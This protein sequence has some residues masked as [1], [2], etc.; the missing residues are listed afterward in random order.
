MLRASFGNRM[1][2]FYSRSVR[3]F[4]VFATFTV[5][6]FLVGITL[7]SS[8]ATAA[9]STRILTKRGSP[10]LISAASMFGDSEKQTVELVGDVQMTFDGQSLRADRATMDKA[11][12]VIKAEGNVIIASPSAYV[13][14]SRA[15]LSYEDNTGLIF[16]GFVKSGQVMFQGKV[17]RKVGVDKY[18]AEQASY[19][20]CTTCPPAWSFSGRQ[21]DA[22]IGAYAHIKSATFFLGGV[23]FFW[24]PYLIVP[25]KSERQSGILFPSYELDIDGFAFGIPF[26]WA[27]SRSQ[28]MTLTPKYYTKRGL[29][30]LINYRYVLNAESEGELN[31]GGFLKDSVFSQDTGLPTRPG[32]ERS[33][34]WFLNHNHIYSL[35]GGF[36]NRAR[37]ALVSDL[38]YTRDFPEDMGGLGEPALENRLSLTKNSERGHSSIEVGYYVNQLKR[39]PLEGNADSVH[40]FPE[41]KQSGVDRSLFNSRV[42]FRWDFNYVNFAREDIAFDDVVL[43]GDPAAPK[44]I[45]RTRGSGGTG[46]GTF[47][48]GVDLIRTGQRLDLRPEISAPFRVGRFLD[49]LPTI[50]FRHTQYSFNVT[51]P[52]GGAFDTLPTRQYVRGRLALRTQMSRIYESESESIETADGFEIQSGDRLPATADESESAS[53]GIFQALQKPKAIVRPERIKHEI[54]PE[55]SVSGIPWIQQTQSPFFSDNASAPIFIDGQPVSNSDFYSTKGLQFDYEDRITQRNIV[56]ML[57]TNRLI[58]KS[59]DEDRAIYRQIVSIKN[60]TSYEFDRPNR[61]ANSNFSDIFTIIDA[62]FQNF[63]SN[64]SIRYFP[65]H[66]VFNTTS[67][68]RGLDDRGNFL[69]VSFSQNFLITENVAEAYPAREENIGFALGFVHRYATISGDINFL[70]A[71]YSPLSLKLKSWA[72]VATIKPPGD[73]WGIRVGITNILTEPTPRYKIDFEYNFGGSS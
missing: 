38:R 7:V 34:R 72:A 27:I 67:R 63:D 33:G 57:V 5:A 6:M 22:E 24:L 62:R 54:E 39:D 28:D 13:E 25:L 11:R 40:R 66:R 48:P 37:L 73:C 60:G 51:S 32:D 2:L 19:T 65:L 23:P 1:P 17:L 70:P 55:I 69:Q 44:D 30:G 61:D 46:S 14:G 4:E 9:S 36:I 8:K 41:L 20:A 71:T 12:G 15:E 16:D 56:S 10:V 59:W 29:K 53:T 50:Q 21:I 42:F 64:T 18:E 47:E 49:I 31:F 45:D 58:K 52:N 68:V 43:T 26:F 35:P 3:A